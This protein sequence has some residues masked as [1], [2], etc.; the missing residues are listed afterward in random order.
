MK[1]WSILTPINQAVVVLLVGFGSVTLFLEKDICNSLR[2]TRRIVV[3]SDVLERSN[4]RVKQFL[5]KKIS[6]YWK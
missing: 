5:P 1:E 6:E 2:A 4:G 3:K